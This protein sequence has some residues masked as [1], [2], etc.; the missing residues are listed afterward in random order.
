MTPVV[1]TVLVIHVQTVQVSMP[2]LFSVVHME[3]LVVLGPEVWTLIVSLSWVTIQVPFSRRGEG[4]LV[5]A[6]LIS[7]GI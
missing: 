4:P 2:V 5:N 3:P 7:L 1:R 6:F